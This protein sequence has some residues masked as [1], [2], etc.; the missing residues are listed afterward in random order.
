MTLPLPPPPPKQ[1]QPLL[2]NYCRTLKSTS[3][4]LKL[5]GF[6]GVWIFLKNKKANFVCLCGRESMRSGCSRRGRLAVMCFIQTGGRGRSLGHSVWGG[7]GGVGNLSEEWEDEGLTERWQRVQL[8]RGLSISACEADRWNPM[9]ASVT[10]VCCQA[11][12]GPPAPPQGRDTPQT[13]PLLIGSS[14]DSP[15]SLP[16]PKLKLYCAQK[17]GRKSR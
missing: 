9:G 8:I 5:G 15:A 10:A 7:G 14:S 11:R 13:P 16:E 6:S 12:A 1:S 2:P 4:T 3:V 17:P